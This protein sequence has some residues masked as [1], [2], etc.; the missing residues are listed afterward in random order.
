MKSASTALTNLLNGSTSFL[1]C[2][3]YT[4][5]LSDGTVMRY[6][7]ADIDISWGGNSFLSGG[8]HLKRGA[9]REVIGVEVDTLEVKASADA[10]VAGLPFTQA[11][12]QGAF[13]GAWLLLE[14]AFLSSWPVVVGTIIRFYGR[15]S[16]VRSGRTQTSF[17]IK[18]VLELLNAPMPRN[19]YQSVCLHTLYDT[20]CAVAKAGYTVTGA[21]TGTPTTTT[22]GSALAQASGYFDQGVLTFTSGACSGLKRTVKSFASGTFTFALP[23]PSPPSAGDTFSV[24]PGCDKTLS[25]CQAKFSNQ[26]RFR[27]F[28]YIPVPETTF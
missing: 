25:T 6:T 24:F 26:T 21:V 14:R 15:V 2:D 10:T 7:S 28:P 16:D 3:L 17:T 8:V 22:V 1:M 23:L 9:T 27:G 4:W 20:G 12:R 13:D 11:V 18:S 5:T 19:L